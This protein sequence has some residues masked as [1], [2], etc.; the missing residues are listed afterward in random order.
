MTRPI[1]LPPSARR[2]QKSLTYGAC[3]GCYTYGFVDPMPAPTTERLPRPG[4]GRSYLYEPKLDG[5]RGLALVDDSDGVRNRRWNDLT[6]AYPEVTASL[7]VVPA[8]TVLDGELVCWNGGRLD[9]GAL[10]RRHPSG[11]GLPTWSR[12]CQSVDADIRTPGIAIGCGPYAASESRCSL[13]ASDV[14]G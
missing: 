4:P 14:S 7:A 9:C 1:G 12:C 13:H 5:F 6:K 8:G 11:T 10:L 3:C 2:L